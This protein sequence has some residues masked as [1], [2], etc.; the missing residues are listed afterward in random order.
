MCKSARD[1]CHVCVC[2][3]PVC[4]CT[5]PLAGGTLQE[6]YEHSQFNIFAHEFR[7][8]GLCACSQTRLG[9]CVSVFVHVGVG[10]QGVICMCI[11]LCFDLEVCVLDGGRGVQVCVGVPSVLLCVY[12][13][14]QHTG[15]AP[16]NPLRL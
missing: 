15:Q 1:S 13:I 16:E 14:S 10:P 2:Q 6:A 12:R 3:N 5:A 9:V 4:L 7:L 11:H 8:V